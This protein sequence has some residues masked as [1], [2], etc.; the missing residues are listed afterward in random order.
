MTWLPASH[1]E[2]LCPVATAVAASAHRWT[3][4]TSRRYCRRMAA[5]CSASASVL[6]STR[7]P[8][9]RNRLAAALHCL[10]RVAEQPEGHCPKGQTRHSGVLPVGD[11]A[12]LLC[13]LG[14]YRA[15]PCSM[16][17]RVAAGIAEAEGRDHPHLVGLEELGR[18]LGLFGPA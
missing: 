5:K 4:G 3:A 12:F 7:L 1:N 17:S 13:R 10:V 6:G 9:Q 11:V 18:I 16:C 15:T 14:S 8:A 2:S